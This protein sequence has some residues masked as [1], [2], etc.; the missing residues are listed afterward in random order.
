M[1]YFLGE[2]NHICDFCGKA[3]SRKSNLSVHIKIHTGETPHVCE[4]CGKG[5]I[6]AHVLRSH[7]NTHRKRSEMGTT[8]RVVKSRKQVAINEEM[9][10]ES[11]D[12]QELPVLVELGD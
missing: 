8:K 7:M 11:D 2:R 5:F 4:V 6:Q 1:L 3:F 9:K 12:S 10:L